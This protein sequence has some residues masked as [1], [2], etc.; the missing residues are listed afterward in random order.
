MRSWDRKL[1]RAEE[2]MKALAEA[3]EG[4][5]K[6]EPYEITRHLEAEDADHVYR[7]S[8]FTDPPECIGIL[9]GDVVHNL[10]S[11]LDHIAFALAKQ[12]S[13]AAGITMSRNQETGIQFPISDS[14]EQFNKQIGSGRLL[15]VEP[16][17]KTIIERLQPYWLRRGDPRK[18]WI[19]VLHRL[20]I[21]DKHRTIPATGAVVTHGAY[22]ALPGGPQPE[23]ILARR[24]HE[25]GVGAEVVRFRFAEPH[26]EVDVDFSPSFTVAIE[27]GWPPNGQAD[28]VLGQYAQHIQDSVIDPLGLFF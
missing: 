7:F 2:H 10:R 6:T 1:A 24:T 8:K 5:V 13:V 4:F 22:D 21:T 17:A 23:M 25:W 12:G 15:Y 11:S 20:D 16:E 3:I 28:A 14:P 9:I 27:E 19:S 18:S 26:P